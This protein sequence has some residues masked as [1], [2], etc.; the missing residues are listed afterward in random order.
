MKWRPRR[1]ADLQG[2]GKAVG[3]K[4]CEMVTADSMPQHFLF[5]GPSG[6]GKTTAARILARAVN[7]ESTDGGD[8]CLECSGCRA[9]PVELN[10]AEARGIDVM[11][12]LIED[13]HYSPM[14]GKKK[15]YLVDEAFGLTKDS[16]NALLK[17][18]EPDYLDS[19]LSHVVMIFCTTETKGIIPTLRNRLVRMDFQSFSHSDLIHLLQS[20]MS[21]ENSSREDIE[22]SLPALESISAVSYGSA[23]YALNV[24]EKVYTPSGAIEMTAETRQLI[25]TLDGEDAQ[26]IDLAKAVLRGKWAEIA[27][28]LSQVTSPPELVRL[29]VA[30]YLKGALLQARGPKEVLAMSRALRIMAEPLYDVRPEHK[31]TAV[32][33]LA[34]MTIAGYYDS[35]V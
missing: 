25:G 29:S 35:S 6:V 23:R 21:W 9:Q 33:A 27:S 28:L 18:T 15:V 8:P 24:L 12:N 11:R 1:F 20:V 4:L 3:R 34:S 10:A 14:V 31:L 7:C 13:M 22:A 2:P 30:G 32:L 19:M 5:V 26:V 17:P 16:Q